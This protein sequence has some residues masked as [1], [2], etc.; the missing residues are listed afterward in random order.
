MIQIQMMSRKILTALGICFLIVGSQSFAFRSTTNNAVVERIIKQHQRKNRLRSAL[1][2][3]PSHKNWIYFISP[4][5]DDEILCCA[6]TIRQKIRAKKSVKFVYITNGDGLTNESHQRAK[7]YGQE[8]QREA[9]KAAQSIGVSR[10]NLIFLNFPDGFVDD[11]ATRPLTSSSTGQS[12]SG[13]QSYFPHTPYTRAALE[14]A[15]SKLFTQFPPTEVYLPSQADKH[16][17]HKASGQITLAAL[18][19][20]KKRPNI[21]GYQIH[22]KHSGILQKNDWKRSLIQM[23]ESQFHD[24]HHQQYLERFAD[25]KE[26]FIQI[27]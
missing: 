24:E 2:R 5:P 18:K 12:A 11:L 16:P 1:K 22:G 25:W 14:N 9:R 3:Q 10:S 17:D 13:S 7:A 27:K 19:N 26:W 6:D 15:L 8:R 21:F 23:F 20:I 4:H